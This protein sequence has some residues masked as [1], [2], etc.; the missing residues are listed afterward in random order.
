MQTQQLQAAE[1]GSGSWEMSYGAPWERGVGAADTIPQR[2]MEVPRL[3][4]DVSEV[5]LNMKEARRHRC[6]HGR[7]QRRREEKASCKERSLVDR[8]CCLDVI[9]DLVIY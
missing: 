2:D 7:R 8:D 1:A 9:T 5:E 3:V 4:P 6:R